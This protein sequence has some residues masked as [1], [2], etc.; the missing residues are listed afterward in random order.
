M[1]HK[2][3]HHHGLDYLQHKL[4]LPSPGMHSHHTG[5]VQHK[6]GILDS[7][8]YYWIWAEENGRHIL[9]GPYQSNEEANRK[10]FAKLHCYFEVV[11]LRTRDEGTASRLLRARLLD[12]SGDIS[13]SFKRIKHTGDE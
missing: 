9:W 1:D 11:P 4:K 2:T 5:S 8:T 13:G 12:D 3:V 10:G 7:R 6:E